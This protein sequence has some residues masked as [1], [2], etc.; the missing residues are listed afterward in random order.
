MGANVSLASM[1]SH[2]LKP[3]ATNLHLALTTQTCSSIFH[4]YTNMTSIMFA[5]ICYI[6]AGAKVPACRRLFKSCC[7]KCRHVSA[8]G[9]F[10]T[11]DT[12]F[13]VGRSDAC[14]VGRSGESFEAPSW[15]TISLVASPFASI[16][17]IAAWFIGRTWRW[18]YSRYV[19]YSSRISPHV[20]PGISTYPSYSNSRLT[21]GGIGA[22]EFAI[23]VGGGGSVSADAEAGGVAKGEGDGAAMGTDCGMGT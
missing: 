14:A 10:S 8:C 3:G 6:G 9:D 17:T 11:V 23:G 7:M 13:G 15:R 1:P 16:D 18:A 5:T 4:L 21:R 12:F 2:C 19:S 22:G 20:L